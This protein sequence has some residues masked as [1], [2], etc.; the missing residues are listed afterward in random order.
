[1]PILKT[2]AAQFRHRRTADVAVADEY[3][4]FQLLLFPFHISASIQTPVPAFVVCGLAVVGACLRLICSDS[5]VF[6]SD[7]H[8]D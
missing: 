1:M 2:L 7:M 6:N 3:N 5:A 8:D 4:C